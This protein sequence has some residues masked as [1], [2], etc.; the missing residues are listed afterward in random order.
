MDS[1]E[2]RAKAESA[3]RWR[4]KNMRSV[5]EHD[6]HQMNIETQRF[7]CFHCGQPNKVDNK[8]SIADN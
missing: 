8:E 2:V 3:E 4:V 1:A 5:C 6:L 7:E